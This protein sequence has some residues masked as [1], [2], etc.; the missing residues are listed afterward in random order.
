MICPHCKSEEVVKMGHYYTK[1]GGEEA[2]VQMQGVW[3]DVCSESD[4][5]EELS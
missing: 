4:K 5:A 3:E 1:T 2:E